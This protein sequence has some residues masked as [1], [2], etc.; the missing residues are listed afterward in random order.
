MKLLNGSELISC[1]NAQ[2][3]SMKKSIW[4]ACAAVAT[5]GGLAFAVP[6]VRNWIDQTV[7]S[8]G[9]NG[10]RSDSA[11][12][13]ERGSGNVA[14]ETSPATESAALRDDR[15][16]PQLVNID[17]TDSLPTGT[18][19]SADGLSLPVPAELPATNEAPIV[20][21]QAL[22]SGETPLPGAVDLGSLPAAPSGCH[23]RPRLQLQAGPIQSVLYRPAG[24]EFHQLPPA[25]FSWSQSLP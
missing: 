4:V 16:L 19:P 24:L 5:A 7:P 2:I 18:S 1:S 13:S 17:S 9:I 12:S 3:I 6:S 15:D 10:Y 22:Q 21:A 20:L 14:A 23:K 11:S 8:L 25:G